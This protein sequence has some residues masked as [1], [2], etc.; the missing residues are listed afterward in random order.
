MEIYEKSDESKGAGT[1]ISYDVSEYSFNMG[2][3]ALKL[4]KVVL[5]EKGRVACQKRLDKRKTVS[6]CV[7]QFDLAVKVL[8]SKFH[9]AQ[10]VG[11]MPEVLLDP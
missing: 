10:T 9:R 1:T 6:T 3:T 7:G 5:I 4:S 2:P 8:E 11:E